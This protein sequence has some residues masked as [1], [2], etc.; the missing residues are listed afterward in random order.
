MVSFGA[1]IYLLRLLP[2]FLRPRHS[3]PR[4]DILPVGRCPSSV[5]HA[6]AVQR[7]SL[8]GRLEGEWIKGRVPEEDKR[9]PPRAAPGSRYLPWDRCSIPS[10]AVCPP[11]AGGVSDWGGGRVFARAAG[12]GSRPGGRTNV[13]AKSQNAG[14]NCAAGRRPSVSRNAAPARKDAGNMLRRNG[15]GANGRQ[16]RPRPRRPPLPSPR[17]VTQ[18]KN[19]HR[20]FATARAV[21]R[22]C[23]NRTA[24]RL[25]TV[26]TSAARS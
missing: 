4:R 1:K 23:A 25:P 17:V 13:T 18:Q 10:K 22:L 20:I 12:G 8:N 7:L 2:G 21:M 3:L 11:G 16:T 5:F 19:I 6:Q 9:D 15:S 26:A 14:G 24:R